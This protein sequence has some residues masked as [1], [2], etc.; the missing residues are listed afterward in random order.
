MFVQ[1]GNGLFQ[2]G[3]VEDPSFFIGEPGPVE[4]QGEHLSQAGIPAAQRIYLYVLI[5]RKG[6]VFFELEGC[7]P[8][9]V[10]WHVVEVP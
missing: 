4:P 8:V 9:F 1:P 5:T 7:I 2:E 6:E 3:S 10:V